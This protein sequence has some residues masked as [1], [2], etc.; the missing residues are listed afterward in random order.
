MSAKATGGFEQGRSLNRP[1]LFCGNNFAHW[2]T[3]MKMYVIDQDLA[4]WQIIETDP[5]T[6]T[7]IKDG[8]NVEKEPKD[9]NVDDLEKSSKNYKAINA[10]YC[11][12]DNNEFN[13]VRSCK[14]AKE[15]WDKL[16]L[17]Y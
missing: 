4:L 3:L 11:A 15:I 1:P 16:V 6:F 5:Y 9:Y 2:H 14:T 17:T 12:L 10:L 13:R 8:R 7:T